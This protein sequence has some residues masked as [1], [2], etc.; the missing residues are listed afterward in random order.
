MH[1][2]NAKT[3][4]EKAR[5]EWASAHDIAT[6][7]KSFEGLFSEPGR[8][9]DEHQSIAGLSCAIIN[10]EPATPPIFYCHGGGFQI[11]SM[12]SHNRIMTE[13]AERSGRPVIGFDYRLAPEHKYPAAMTDGLHVYSQLVQGR[14]ANRISIAGDSAGGNLAVGILQQ[15]KKAG[16]PLPDRLVLISPWLDLGLTGTSYSENISKDIFS[17]PAALRLMVRGY[18]GRGIDTQDPCISPINVRFENWMPPIL[19]HAGAHDITLSDSIT[20]SERGNAA[21]VS[22]KLKIWPEMFHHFQMFPELEQSQESLTEIGEFLA[23]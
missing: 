17:T 6:I 16:L 9:I 18:L 2:S 12:V 15:A 21:G 1:L 4:I 7:R 19:I 3:K 8:Q 14:H 10:P 11:G 5:A 23:T 22:V 20:F 13:I